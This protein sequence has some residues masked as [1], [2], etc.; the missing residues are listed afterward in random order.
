M[1][2]QAC[3][4]SWT[5]VFHT[6][7]PQPKSFKSQIL[8]LEFRVI[9]GDF[10]D[11]FLFFLEEQR[12]SEGKDEERQQCEYRLYMAST[13]SAL[14]AGVLLI[15]KAGESGD[16]KLILDTK[17]ERVA[18]YKKRSKRLGT[19][20]DCET[21]EWTPECRCWRHWKDT[22]AGRRSKTF[23]LLFL[24]NP[25]TFS[26]TLTSER[27]LRILILNLEGAGRFASR[28]TKHTNYSRTPRICRIFQVHGRNFNTAIL[29]KYSQKYHAMEKW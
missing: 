9:T 20:Q 2:L 6:A 26:C 19:W 10:R 23:T 22:R 15:W 1:L 29:I 14:S 12:Q 18:E 7:L 16:V 11:F 24:I 28:F 13:L 25:L 3:W 5:L 27:T 17:G 8:P 4:L 21:A